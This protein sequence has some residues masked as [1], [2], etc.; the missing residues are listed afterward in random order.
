MRR[1]ASAGLPVSKRYCL[2]RSVA[3]EAGVLRA[4]RVCTQAQKRLRSV[5][6]R[7]QAQWNWSSR[8]AS[9]EAGLR[10]AALHVRERALDLLEGDLRVA[11]GRETIQRKDQKSRSRS[12]SRKSSERSS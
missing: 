6:A 1:T 7:A 8:T 9:R 10:E 4:S 11:P 5:R 2:A 3:R 12:S